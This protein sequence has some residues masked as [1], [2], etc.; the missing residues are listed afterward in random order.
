MGGWHYYY[1]VNNR[2]TLFRL[3]SPEAVQDEIIKYRTNNRTFTNAQDVEREL[4]AYWCSL[5]PERCGLP[6]TPA[7]A[8]PLLPL[9]QRPEFFGPIIW[10]FLNLAASRFDET[11]KEFF[12]QLTGAIFSLMGCPDCRQE[13]ASI[14]A[15][16]PPSKVNSKKKRRC[17]STGFITS[18]MPSAGKLHT[19][20]RK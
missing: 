1:D 3:Y 10:R 17:G 4:W 7:N 18:S 13:Y 8:G 6:A 15:V 11:G 14:V 2:E 20:T 19:P 12:L 16:D 5:H 9:D